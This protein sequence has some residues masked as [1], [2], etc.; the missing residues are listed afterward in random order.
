MDKEETMVQNEMAKDQV[1]S[2]T[3]ADE[4]DAGGDILL[5]AG[6]GGSESGKITRDL[7]L[8]KN[9]HIVLIPQPSEDPEDPLNWTSRKKHMMLFIVALSAFLGDL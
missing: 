1:G 9:G 6:M 7:K 2:K 4:I 5:D 8:A 3:L